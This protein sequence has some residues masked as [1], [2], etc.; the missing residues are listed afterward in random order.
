MPLA[1]QEAYALQ[2]GDQLTFGTEFSY[3]VVSVHAL[4]GGVY[5]ELK[6]NDGYLTSAREHDLDKAVKVEAESM[7]VIESEETVAAPPKAKSAPR[8]P[9][10]RKRSAK[11]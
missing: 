3:E 2:P 1:L 10:Q 6:R 11:S 4:G 5:I 7:P 9:V 8:K